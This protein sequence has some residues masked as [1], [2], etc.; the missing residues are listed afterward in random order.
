MVEVCEQRLIVPKRTPSILNDQWMWSSSL[1]VPKWGCFWEGWT[2]RGERNAEEEPRWTPLNQMNPTF[3]EREKLTWKKM[4]E[5][6]S[7]GTTALLFVML[8]PCGSPWIA[9][10]QFIPAQ[11]SRA[12]HRTCWKQCKWCCYRPEIEP[13]NWQ[14]LFRVGSTWRVFL[15]WSHWSIGW[16]IVQ[17]CSL[18]F[19][20]GG[21]TG[22]T[23]YLFE[24]S[25]FFR[26][27]SR[28]E[29]NPLESHGKFLLMEKKS[30]E[31]LQSPN[32][33][34]IVFSKYNVNIISNIM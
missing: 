1:T 28:A 8:C 4:S 18:R 17:D 6:S 32:Y 31:I 24:T 15:A 5:G 20:W 22:G 23:G 29:R 33:F 2:W 25:R 27:F 7:K 13:K 19:S 16:M 9:S 11:V 14:C 26:S 21:V 10:L 3:L 34:Y 12:I 30:I